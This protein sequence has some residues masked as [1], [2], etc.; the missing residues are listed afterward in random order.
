MIPLMMLSGSFEKVLVCVCE[1]VC[2]EF[3]KLKMSDVMY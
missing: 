2:C 3:A 1:V